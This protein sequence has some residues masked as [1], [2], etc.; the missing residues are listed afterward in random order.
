MMKRR[1]KMEITVMEKFKKK[2]SKRLLMLKRKR[3]N[4]SRH[5]PFHSAKK[6]K[7]SNA[8]ILY[9]ALQTASNQAD[10]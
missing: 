2:M 3:K 5:L 9:V 4:D 7:K 8:E 6:K 1:K 10:A